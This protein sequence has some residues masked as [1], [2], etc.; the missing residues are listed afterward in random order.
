MKR[1]RRITILF[2]AAFLLRLAVGCC[3]CEDQ[4]YSFDYEQIRIENIDNSGQWSKPSESNSMP[5]AGVAFEIQL[6]GSDPVLTT[7]S[8]LKINGFNTAS[9]LGC[10]CEELYVANHTITEIKIRTLENLNAD[11]CCN[12]DVTSLFLANSCLS[13]DDVGNFYVTIDELVRR[14][15][16]E[17]FYQKQVNKFLIY[18]KVPVENTEAQFEIEVML[19]NGVSITSQ[20]KRIEII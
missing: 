2:V 3:G 6:L 15:N 12:E 14:I 5:A 13:C 8:R 17:A 19:S 20:T 7:Q 1:F 10:N 4:F 16:P 9:A 18:L 11:Y